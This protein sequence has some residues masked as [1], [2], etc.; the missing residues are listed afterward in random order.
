MVNRQVRRV[1]HSRKQAASVANALY[2][3]LRPRMPQR[4]VTADIPT[5]DKPR[6][7]AV[8]RPGF[9]GGSNS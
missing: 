6:R 1:H 4:A 7:Y 2:T 3:L 8:N 5:P 9:A